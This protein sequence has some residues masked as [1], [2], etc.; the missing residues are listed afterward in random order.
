MIS[1]LTAAL[2]QL[3]HIA[4]VFS[5]APVVGS[6]Q[7]WA[8]ARVQGRASPHL[9][10]AWRDL[11]RL[12]RKRCAL[13]ENAS[14]LFSLLPY[15]CFAAMAVAAALVPSFTLGMAFAPMADLLVIAALMAAARV[16]LALAALDAGT[17]RGGLAAARLTRLG[18]MG[19]PA[20]F[21][22]ILTLGVMGAT[23]NL[24]LL[25]DLQ[26]DG[27]L[28][29]PVASALAGAALAIVVLI[30]PGW[31][32]AAAEFSA[33]DLALVHYAQSLRQIVWLDLI[34][35][36]FLPIGIAAAGDGPVAWIVGV[37]AW[38]AKLVFLAGATSVVR[39]VVRRVRSAR[40]PVMLGVA[41][42]ASLLAGLI[43]L[44][45]TRAV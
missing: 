5:A 20:V 3:L 33:T 34:A 25:A 36:L 24:D 12:A 1:F 10:Q 23:T 45:G 7:R 15:G 16:M 30:D 18:G 43:V 6:L 40:V 31:G 37:A 13:A 29:P 9:L 14:P 27:M 41:A 28:V 8:A 22:V 4:L 21:L 26:R 32:D 19:E 2:A 38:V 39:S 17:G 42:L 11:S 35:A 44:A